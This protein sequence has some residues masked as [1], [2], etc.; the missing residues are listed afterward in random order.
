GHVT[1]CGSVSISAALL[2]AVFGRLRRRHPGLSM[3]VVPAI[4]VERQFK[5]LRER[6]ADLALG[7]LP[8]PVDKDIAAALLY[9]AQLVVV[10]GGR[11]ANGGDDATSHSPISQTSLGSCLLRGHFCRR[12]SRMRSAHMTWYS[13][14]RARRQVQFICSSHCSPADR[15]FWQCRDPCCNS[16]R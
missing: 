7:R 16:A 9:H 4:S 8:S 14:R 10:A 11:E 15:L 13:R 2:P 5:E 12:S 6:K 1:I 3:H